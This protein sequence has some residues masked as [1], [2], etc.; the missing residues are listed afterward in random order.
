MSQAEEIWKK[1][2]EMLSKKLTSTTINTFFEGTE[3]VDITG[4]AIVV[5]V[6]SVVAKEAIST[7]YINMIEEC[8]LQ[9]FSVPIS[10]ILLSGEEELS[11]FRASKNGD[12]GLWTTNE[13]TFANFV[14]GPSNR[15]AHAAA[16]AVA[17]SPAAA[18]NPLFI[19]GGSGL[20]KTHLLYAIANKIRKEKPSQKI[21]YK[22]GEDFTN[23]L[24]AA[25]RAGKNV[26]FRE[27][28]RGADLF[29]IDDTQF[30]AGKDSTQEEFFHTFNALYE[31]GKQIVLTADRPPKEMARLEDRLK[32]RFEWGLLCDIQPPDLETRVAI[33]R[34]KAT[35]IG[36]DI[37]DEAVM[38]MAENITANVRQIEGV[39]KKLQA[40]KY[41]L[42]AKIDVST[43][44]KAIKD[45]FQENPG[46]N[47]TPEIIIEE[48]EKFYG[49]NH[50]EIVGGSRGRAITQARHIAVYL[51]RTLTKL[52]LPDIGASFKR[53]HSTI[54]HSIETVENQRK[55]DPKLDAD[56]K[57]LIENI[58]D[59]R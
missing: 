40:Y 25:I 29:L 47:P 46:L 56:I 7:H 55:D 23:E 5:S 11:A 35:A 37:N 51:V 43:V 38:Y 50:G 14:V 34:N 18:Y 54:M 48:T 27:K 32:S 44:S 16:V 8:L 58:K 52:S 31:A 21:I 2:I 45:I 22:R 13:F 9:L 30:I 12:N 57:D 24:I 33:I 17:N 36:L 53:H 42:D 39:V 20:G 26:E 15:F 41:L 4:S 6:R 59:H 28:Y 1:V 49:L 19:Y 10:C 3:G